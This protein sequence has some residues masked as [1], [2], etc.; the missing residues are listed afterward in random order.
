MPASVMQ[1]VHSA[2]PEAV[3]LDCNGTS[4]PKLHIRIAEEWS[5]AMCMP[6]C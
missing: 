1:P 6:P 3:Q 4:A 5:S 2:I